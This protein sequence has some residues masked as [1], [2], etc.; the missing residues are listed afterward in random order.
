[1]CKMGDFFKK[2]KKVEEKEE[3]KLI[4][5][6]NSLCSAYDSL[7][8]RIQET[9]NQGYEAIL[10]IRTEL[11]GAGGGPDDI[12]LIGHLRRRIERSRIQRMD[13]GIMM[14]SAIKNIE[15]LDKWSERY[16]SYLEEH[17]DA[18]QVIVKSALKIIDDLKG[19]VNGLKNKVSQMEDEMITQ[20]ESLPLPSNRSSKKSGKK[21]KKRVSDELDL[22]T[23]EDDL[24]EEELTYSPLFEKNSKKN[25]V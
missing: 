6:F 24:T 15:D 14:W 9:T 21:P 20:T 3:D 19:E 25:G 7:A 17:L 11:V 4:T 5:D 10:P 22:S 2:E 13:L 8:N 16:S 18:L 23:T 1:M 12:G